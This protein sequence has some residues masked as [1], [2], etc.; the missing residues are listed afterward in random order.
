MSVKKILK[1]YLKY[2]FHIMTRE[3]KKVKFKNDN[4][5]N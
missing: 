3:A 2:Y 4:Q 5:D 1:Y